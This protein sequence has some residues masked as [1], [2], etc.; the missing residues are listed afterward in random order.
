MHVK[1]VI[2]SIDVLCSWTSKDVQFYLGKIWRLF[3]KIGRPRAY[4][5][6]GRPKKYQKMPKNVKSCPRTSKLANFLPVAHELQP[7]NNCI[8]FIN[9]SI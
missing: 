8:L 4:D 3:K 6:N 9:V 7:A 5:V 1:S 2:T